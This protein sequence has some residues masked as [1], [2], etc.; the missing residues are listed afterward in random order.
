LLSLDWTKR[1]FEYLFDELLQRAGAHTAALRIQRYFV[2]FAKLDVAIPDPKRITPAV[3]LA[4]FG[5]EAMRRYNIPLGYLVKAG[6]LPP[7]EDDDLRADVSRRT[8]L[9]ILEQSAE[10]WFDGV[11]RRFLEHQDAVSARYIDRGWSGKRRRFTPRTITSN[12]RSAAKFLADVDDITSIQQLSQSHLDAFLLDHPGYRDGVR[13]FVRFLNRKEKLFKKL[14]VRSIACGLPAGML[15]ERERYRELL[16]KWTNPAETELKPSLIGLLMLLYA[17][18]PHR[19]ARLR[20]SDLSRGT[21]GTYRVA[22]GRCEVAL[23]KHVS[24]VL[25]RYLVSRRA[26]AMMDDA[27]ANAYLFPGRRLG[28]HISEAMITYYLRKESLRADNLFATA[29]FYAYL[30]G[31][32]QPKVLSRGFGITDQTAVRYLHLIDPR[33]QDEVSAK[34]AMAHA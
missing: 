29:V 24:I 21:D 25:Q 16:V 23:S 13:S 28:G 5:A 7:V 14:E 8:Q 33:L 3:L 19:I 4:T 34:M 31:V 27:W 6:V 32:R 18:P 26:A 1:H 9:K 12:L 20:L 22:F 11:L 2:F 17:Q 10:R 15:V 30:G